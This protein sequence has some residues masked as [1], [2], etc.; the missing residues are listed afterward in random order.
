MEGPRGEVT[1]V[2]EP[3]VQNRESVD[4]A[5]SATTEASASV[6]PTIKSLSQ[7]PS[8]NY[9]NLSFTF[10][11]IEDMGRAPCCEKVGLKKGRWTAQEDQILT[12]YIRANGEGSWRSLPKNAGLL[13]CGKSCRLRWINYLRDDLKRGNISAQ[14]EQTIIQLHASLGN[15]WSII[16]SELPGRTDNEI[17]NYWNSH[18]SRK[19]Y[20]LRPPP[21]ADNSNR[22]TH[23]PP[24]RKGRGR[25]SPSSEDLLEV[26][27]IIMGDHTVD[28]TT[29]SCLPE[30]ASGGDG[31]FKLSEERER[32]DV[33]EE[34]YNNNYWEW[35][36]HQNECSSSDEWHKQN[37]LSWLWEDD[38]LERDCHVTAELDSQKLDDMLAWFLSS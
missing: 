16:A 5:Q 32:N 10:T 28:T 15:R 25:T 3:R 34:W 33:Q 24:K 9:L 17:K 29:H 19:I 13:R 26:L 35:D 21:P 4:V 36:S 12:N 30:G 20:G 18:L 14:E 1:T 8:I 2:E 38:D 6:A 22:N 31:V 11:P 7:L 23:T 27:D 37:L